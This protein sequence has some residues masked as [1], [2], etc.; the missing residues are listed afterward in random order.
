[1]ILFH[2]SGLVYRILDKTEYSQAGKPINKDN[3]RKLTDTRN[4]GLNSTADRLWSRQNSLHLTLQ[5]C[6]WI[7]SYDG[8]VC[9]VKTRQSRPGQRLWRERSDSKDLYIVE[10]SPSINERPNRWA[11][12]SGQG[13]DYP[14]VTGQRRSPVWE[15]CQRK[16]STLSW[17]NHL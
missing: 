15:G 17:K 14:A 16:P 7:L 10:T 5:S 4:L 13:W 9:W 1:M 2:H 3:Q 8:A 12:S 6:F 11:A